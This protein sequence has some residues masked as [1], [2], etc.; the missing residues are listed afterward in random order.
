MLP[1]EPVPLFLFSEGRSALAEG[2]G[3]NLEGRG[4]DRAVAALRRFALVEVESIPDE[5][6]PAITTET[7]RLHRLIRMAALWRRDAAAT[8]AI[9]RGLFAAFVA[10]YPKTVFEP[11]SWPRCRRLDPVATALLGPDVEQTANA[12]TRFA[13][14]LIW[15]GQYRKVAAAYRSIA[16]LVA[17]RVATPVLMF[18]AGHDRVVVTA[19]TKRF[20]G[21]MPQSVYRRLE[22]AEH[23]ILMERDVF[24]T[25]FWSAFDAFMAEH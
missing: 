21:R 9:Q 13:D 20:A 24:R 12:G 4:I 11:Q 7:I 3:K 8:T 15:V 2:L 17:R 25:Q 6:D 16:G 22:G 18:G 10:A 1:P 19:A 5:R 23:E 14:M